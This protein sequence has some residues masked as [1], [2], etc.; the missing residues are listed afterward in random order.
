MDEKALIICIEVNRMGK[1][2]FG[3]VILKSIAVELKNEHFEGYPADKEAYHDCPKEKDM[4]FDHDMKVKKDK[5]ML[6]PRGKLMDTIYQRIFGSYHDETRMKKLYTKREEGFG[7]FGNNV[8]V[9]EDSNKN[10]GL[11]GLG[12]GGL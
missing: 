3:Y 2:L 4:W 1:Y 12:F 5:C 11:F 6:G 9:I 10:K 8:P 7:R